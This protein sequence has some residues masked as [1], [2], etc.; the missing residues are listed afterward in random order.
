M[1]RRERVRKTFNHQRAD[2]VP[3]EIALTPPAAA[4]VSKYYGDKRVLEPE[5]YLRW[6]GN[7]CRSLEPTGRGLFHGLEE[8]V[9]PGQWRDGWGIVWD[10]RGMYGEGEWGR[11]SN[12]R[13]PAPTLDHFDFPDPPGPEAFSHYPEF[14]ES[15]QE[16]FLVGHEGHLFEVAYA[17]RGLENLLV[18]MVEHSSFVE[19]LLDGITEYHLKMIDIAVSYDIDAFAFGD[20]WGTQNMGLLMGPK[21]WRRYIKPRMAQLFA[22]VKEAGKL[23]HLHSDGDVEAIFDDLIEIGLDIYNPL[24]PEILNVFEIKKEYGDR[25]SFHGGVGVQSTLPLG[26]PQQVRES[27]RRLIDEVGESGGLLISQAHPE[28]VLDDAPVENIVALLETVWDQ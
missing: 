7:H 22:R 4:K 24:Q 13:L 27:V 6:S 9:A 28:G 17:L 19:E 14:I 1:T 3:W 12:C 5:Y 20:D 15:N 10:T 25:L 11:P 26:T 16:Y 2:K 23:V 8:E 21:Y 18:D